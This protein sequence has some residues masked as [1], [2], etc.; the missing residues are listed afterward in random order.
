MQS[1]VTDDSKQW[2]YV[3]TDIETDGPTPG[4]NSMRSFASIAVSPDGTE[5]ERFEAV[6]EPLPGT[7]PDPDSHRL[8]ACRRQL[9]ES[10]A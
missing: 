8:A 1:M 2:V 5:Y 4:V 9:T 3:V 7:T 10:S 6:L